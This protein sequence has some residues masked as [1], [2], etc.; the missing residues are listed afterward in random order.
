VGA[1]TPCGVCTLVHW[2]GETDFPLTGDQVHDRISR[3]L[4]L[5]GRALSAMI[6]AKT[7]TALC[8]HNIVVLFNVFKKFKRSKNSLQISDLRT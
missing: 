6:E 8:I 1:L 4:L 2:T 7:T 3:V 5:E